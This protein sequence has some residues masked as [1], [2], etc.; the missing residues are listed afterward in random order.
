M[1]TLPNEQTGRKLYSCAGV[2]GLQKG[3]SD[4]YDSHLD[5]QWIDVTGLNG[6]EEWT[7][8]LEVNP[9]RIIPESDYDNNV[10][11]K[12]L[13]CEDG[14]N[15]P[16]VSRCVF[17]ECVCYSGVDSPHCIH[18]EGWDDSLLTEN[19][20]FDSLSS[21]TSDFNTETSTSHTD[22]CS[23]DS[24]SLKRLSILSLLLLPLLY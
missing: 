11:E 17:G 23:S 7:L 4:V 22:N 6:S 10:S 9:D 2:Q 21:S 16:D 13:K 3:W 14:C 12:D 1:D 15:I 20:N 19:P 5:C 8:E 24:S 18:I